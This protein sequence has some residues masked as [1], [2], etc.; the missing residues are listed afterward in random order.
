MRPSAELPLPSPD[1]PLE[2]VAAHAT[3]RAIS[4]ERAESRFRRRRLLEYLAKQ[5]PLTLSGQITQV[6]ERGFSVDLPQFGTWGFV[7][8][9]QLP[10]G[11]YKYDSGVLRG[12]HHSFQLGATLEVRIGRIDAAAN[13]F[14]LIPEL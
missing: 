7:M 14:E 5:K 4:A 11:P 8:A 13:E 9:G 6:V 10:R 2:V 12:P 3:Q 1:E